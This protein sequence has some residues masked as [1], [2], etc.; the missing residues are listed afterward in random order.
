MQFMAGRCPGR[1]RADPALSNLPVRRVSH[2]HIETVV[3]LAPRIISKIRL[4]K[5]G[6]AKTVDP[7][8]LGC[9]LHKFGLDL[10]SDDVAEGVFLCQQQAHEPVPTSQVRHV[11]VG[12]RPEKAGEKEAVHGSFHATIALDKFDRADVVIGFAHRL[13]STFQIPH[14]KGET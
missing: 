9:L 3:L 10:D 14:S 2:Y 13:N 12:H 5:T 1:I 11:P 4:D 7:A 8:V 6:V